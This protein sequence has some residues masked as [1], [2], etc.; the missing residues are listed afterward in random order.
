MYLVVGP[1]LTAAAALTVR[2]VLLALVFRRVTSASRQRDW[3][4]L[5]LHA[6]SLLTLVAFG[7]LGHR[8]LSILETELA[9]DDAEGMGIL[10]ALLAV[11]IVILV[12]YILWR[13]V[14][15]M[16]G[17]LRV[18]LSA[19]YERLE[20]L[21]VLRNWPQ[22][23]IEDPGSIVEPELAVK[24]ELSESTDAPVEDASETEPADG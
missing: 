14:D 11:V 4:S 10:M 9:A 1:L 13:V 12:V 19:D 15:R 3:R 6:V 18:R 21:R 7:V 20:F 16:Y 2:A 23:K 17:R 5:T 22:E 24:E 8:Y